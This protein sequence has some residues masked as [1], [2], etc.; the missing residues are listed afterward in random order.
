[1][2]LI[3][4]RKPANKNVLGDNLMLDTRCF[5]EQDSSPLLKGG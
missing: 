2:Q 5:M 3:S 4:Q 1:M